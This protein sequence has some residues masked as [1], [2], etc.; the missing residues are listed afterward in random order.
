MIYEPGDVFLTKGD[1]F[2]SRAI[3]YFSR[4]GGESR[5]EANH[6]G[7][8]VG[9][10]SAQT[11][12]IVEAL[13]TV[14][15][16]KMRSY[17]KSRKTAVAVFRPVNVDEVT[18][19]RVVKDATDYVGAKYGYVKIVA[20]FADWCL[21]GRYVF[22]KWAQMDRYPICSWVVAFAWNEGGRSFGVPPEAASPDDIW[23]YCVAHPHEWKMI[24]PMTPFLK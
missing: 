14:K 12:T 1:S 19:R 4:S 22:R 13:S 2:V 21:G 9:R 8:V 6:T 18:V 3:R 5:T 23:D 24:H 15:Q 17:Y 10:G 7:V 20:H 11:A 16:R